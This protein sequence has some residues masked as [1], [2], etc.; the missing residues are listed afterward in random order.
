MFE[1]LVGVDG[2][3][4]H[5]R[6]VVALPGG[7]AL[8]RGRAGPS[9][10]GQGIASAWVQLRS[11]ILAAFSD[12]RIAAP[13][14]DRC[15]LGAGLSGVSYAPWR[16]AFIA[17]N[18]GFSPLAIDTDAFTTLL[19]AHDGKPG[20]IV[21][22]GTGSI[23]EAL[24]ADGTR[25]RVG[26]WGFPW[27]DEGSGAW[28]GLEAVRLAHRALDGRAPMGALAHHVLATCGADREA[29]VAWRQAAG[30]FDYAQLAPAVFELAPQD[31]DAEHL[32]QEAARELESLAHALDPDG[33]LPLALCGSVGE[34]L[35][36]RWSFA[37]QARC[38]VPIGDAATGALHLIRRA[39]ARAS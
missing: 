13:P 3:G 10:L 28:L 16:D 35:A 2:G 14:W 23:G 19:G 29:L 30:P 22:A 32:L 21:A 25:R 27:G 12:A 37:L 4:T 20:A 11:A 31:R 39:G 5:T 17:Q 33:R 36:G 15:A 18:I 26:G 34:R 6:A 1:F 8:G 9:A 24:L 7:Q 38:V